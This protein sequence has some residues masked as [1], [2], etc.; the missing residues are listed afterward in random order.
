MLEEQRD[1]NSHRP[2]TL[3]SLPLKYAKIL[4]RMWNDWAGRAFELPAP[5]DKQFLLQP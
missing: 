2:S 4:V 1:L 3:K 5:W